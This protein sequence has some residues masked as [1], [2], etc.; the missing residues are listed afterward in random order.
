LPL[1]LF[2]SRFC[3]D[4]FKQKRYRT[5]LRMQKTRYFAFRKILQDSTVQNSAD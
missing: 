5:K 1:R 4:W 3:K 2:S